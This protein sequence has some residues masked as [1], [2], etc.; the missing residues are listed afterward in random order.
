MDCV[1]YNRNNF[2]SLIKWV[3]LFGQ[4][5]LRASLQ[6]CMSAIIDSDRAYAIF[7]IYTPPEN[8]GI[9]CKSAGRLSFYQRIRF[10][11]NESRILGGTF[12]FCIFL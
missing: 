10:R 1:C 2:F 5:S 12:W 3:L 11:K 4:S 6:P 8:G 7:Q 9:K